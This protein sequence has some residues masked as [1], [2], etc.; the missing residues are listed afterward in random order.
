LTWRD[1]RWWWQR[2]QTAPLSIAAFGDVNPH[3]A[4]WIDEEGEYWIVTV[5]PDGTAFTYV[6]IQRKELS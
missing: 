1:S 3:E 5:S 4:A 6:G 2:G